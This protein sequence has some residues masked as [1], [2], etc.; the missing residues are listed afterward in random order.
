[1]LYRD[2]VCASY[3]RMPMKAIRCVQLTELQIHE[4]TK[5]NVEIVANNQSPF[6]YLLLFCVTC[7]GCLIELFCL[8]TSNFRKRFNKSQQPHYLCV[9]STNYHNMFKVMTCRIDPFPLR[10]DLATQLGF[11]DFFSEQCAAVWP[12]NRKVKH[13]HGVQSWTWSQHKWNCG[14]ANVNHFPS[15]YFWNQ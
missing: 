2:C 7:F 9:I 14:F 4:T 6:L 5:F 11:K 10:N 1:M 15:V 8:N 12:S 3:E 13:I